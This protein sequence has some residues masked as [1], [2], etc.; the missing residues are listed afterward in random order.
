MMRMVALTVLVGV[1]LCSC[2]QAIGQAD[3]P[4]ALYEAMRKAMINKDWNAMIDCVQPSIIQQGEKQAEIQ[5]KELAKNEV[6]LKQTAD[7]FGV[8]PEEFMKMTYREIVIAQMK[9]STTDKDIQEAKDSKILGKEIDGNTCRFKVQT[10]ERIDFFKVVKEGN[11]W[12]WAGPG[13]N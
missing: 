1:L 10:G 11:R 6:A 5:K 9:K 7:F 4:E 3:T 13:G 8:K 12:Y 2:G